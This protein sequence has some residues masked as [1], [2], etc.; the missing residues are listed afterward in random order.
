MISL[1]LKD[2]RIYNYDFKMTIPT[3]KDKSQHDKSTELRFYH[4]TQYNSGEHSSS[5]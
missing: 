2:N 5:L 1:S 4:C 3:K